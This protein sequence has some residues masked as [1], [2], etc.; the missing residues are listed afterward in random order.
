MTEPR[1]LLVVGGYTVVIFGLAVAV[2]RKKMK[3]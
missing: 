2:F 3:G 1:H